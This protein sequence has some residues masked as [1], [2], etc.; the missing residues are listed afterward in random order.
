MELSG[1]I[2]I[3][4]E[5]HNIEKLCEEMASMQLKSTDITVAIEEVTA[6]MKIVAEDIPMDFNDKD[7]SKD[8]S[9]EELCTLKQMLLDFEKALDAIPLSNSNPEGTHFEGSY[10]YQIFKKAEVN[11]SQFL[12][13]IQM[14][15]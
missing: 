15:F 4:D 11:Q 2:V 13:N 6:V 1:A 12:K 3:L 5:A 8:F 14:I 10:I 7:V 9:P